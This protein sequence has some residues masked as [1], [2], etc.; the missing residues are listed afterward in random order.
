MS[1]SYYKCALG[2]VLDSTQICIYSR[3]C[4]HQKW[5]KSERIR[6]IRLC[7]RYD[8]AV[9]VHKSVHT[10][11]VS[12]RTSVFAKFSSLT[13]RYQLDARWL[14]ASATNDAVR[15]HACVFTFWF[16]VVRFGCFTFLTSAVLLHRHLSQRD[17]F[18]LGYSD[19]TDMAGQLHTHVT[20]FVFV[21]IDALLLA[22]SAK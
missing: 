10:A 19:L 11:S 14:Q 21:V 9:S 8:S 6:F 13:F 4:T 17:P 15:T 1:P 18:K 3:K 16:L 20:F 2:F 7:F 12:V 5:R 22:S